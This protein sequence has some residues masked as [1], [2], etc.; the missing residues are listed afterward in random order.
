[1]TDLLE[2][3]RRRLASRGIRK[4]AIT[5]VPI[6]T[7]GTVDTAISDFLAILNS[8]STG[9]ALYV[10]SCLCPDDFDVILDLVRLDLSQPQQ[11]SYLAKYEADLRHGPCED[12]VAY[13]RAYM[14]ILPVRDQGPFW[15][16]LTRHWLLSCRMSPAYYRADETGT[17]IFCRKLRSELV[18][19][20][21][22]ID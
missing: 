6:R 16:E 11:R 3:I 2:R 13:L 12:L 10:L 4:R 22:R 20:I 5:P 19:R 18:E 21:L 15:L 8:C 17:E 1:M 14:N 7:F 9:T